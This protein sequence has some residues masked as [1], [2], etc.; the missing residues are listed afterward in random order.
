MHWLEALDT[1]LFRFINGSLS[2]SLFDSLMPILSGGNGVMRW[3]ILAAVLAF[4][5]AMIFGGARARLCAVMILAAAALGNGLVINTMKQAVHRPRPCIALP[6]VVERLGCTA[7][8]SMPSA[9]AANWFA[10][11]MIVFIFYRRKLWLIWPVFLMAVAVSFSRV[12]CGVHYP[13]DVFVGATLGAG[14]AA[15]FAVALQWAWQKLGRA[16]FPLWHARMPSLLNPE[17]RGEIANETAVNDRIAESQW[18]RLGFLFIIVSLIA[19]WIYV[20]SGLIGLSG[21]EAYQWLWSKHLAL[22]YYS[23]PPGIAWIQFAG[24]SLFGDNE[25]GVRFFSPLFAAILSFMAFGFVAREIGARL[26]FWLLI[27]V[28]AV[29]LLAVGSIFMTIDPPLVLCWTWALIAGW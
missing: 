14:Y 20:A 12:Y 8:G 5:A 22:G 7:S 23:K 4:V 16:W 25:L 28:S 21:D 1:A 26:A 24:T 6:N 11:T 27:I 10:A 29:P 18:L 17:A 19:R 3:F 13:G 15:A 2:N 9:H